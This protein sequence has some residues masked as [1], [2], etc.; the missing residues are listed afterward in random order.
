MTPRAYVPHE[1]MVAPARRSSALSGTIVGFLAIEFFYR[2]GLEALDFFVFNLAPEP[3]A[4]QLFGPGPLGELFALFSFAV[5]VLAVVL[6]VWVTH[7]RGARSLLGEQGRVRA[8]LVRATLGGVGIFLALEIA[9]PWWDRDVAQ[10]RALDQWLA[11]LP[12]AL[13]ALFVQTAAEE[14]FYR[15]Y[16]QQQIAARFSNPL[17]WMVVPNVAF[18][19][20][21]WYN[22]GTLAES[23]QYVIWAFVFGLAA[24]DLTARTGS[25]GAAI[26][27]H[28]ANNIFAFLVAGEADNPDGALALFLLPPFEGEDLAP[29]AEPILTPTLGMDLLILVLA[30]LAVRLAVRR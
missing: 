7:R 21:H 4:E 30:W 19:S 24:S 15:G 17:V 22:G 26:G 9:M 27:F 1:G 18:A 20:V 10:M 2:L 12:W 6:V 16:L 14:V 25:L 13:L 5:L 3:V 23:W 8:D 29:M 11:L 28:L